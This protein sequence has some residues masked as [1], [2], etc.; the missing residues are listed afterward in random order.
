MAYVKSFIYSNK[1]YKWQHT[2]SQLNI[3]LILPF[4]VH[5]RVHSIRMLSLPLTS[6]I[7]HL[8][9]T[10]TASNFMVTSIIFRTFYWALSRR[11]EYRRSSSACG[12]VGNV[13]AL[14]IYPQAVPLPGL[15]EKLI[16][17]DI[18]K[19]VTHQNV[20][21]CSLRLSIAVLQSR[22]IIARCIEK[23]AIFMPFL[24]KHNLY[25]CFKSLHERLQNDIFLFIEFSS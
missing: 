24:E 9:G 4:T 8:S 20:H 2:K 12:Y 13:A 17:H 21:L 5:T 3:W 23:I 22:A 14:S 16:L 6:F 18:Y 10:L 15:L 1:D 19:E 11:Q 7:L 25:A